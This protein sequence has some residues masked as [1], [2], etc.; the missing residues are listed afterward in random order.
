MS[1]FFFIL[2]KNKFGDPYKPYETL[3]EQQGF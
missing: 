2:F 3:T 1:L